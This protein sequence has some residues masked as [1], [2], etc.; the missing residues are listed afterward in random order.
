MSTEPHDCGWNS[1]RARDAVAREFA[2]CPCAVQAIE[3]GSARTGRLLDYVSGPGLGH[4]HRVAL[5]GQI[6][7]EDAQFLVDSARFVLHI[8]VMRRLL[9]YGYEPE[10]DH[11]G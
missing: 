9:E 3:S 11:S 7:P 5:R 6:G 10:E 8:A 4:V 2:V 1:S